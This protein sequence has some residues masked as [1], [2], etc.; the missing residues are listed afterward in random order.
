MKSHEKGVGIFYSVLGYGSSGSG[1][2]IPGFSPLMFE[3]EVVDKPAEE[4]E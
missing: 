2:A 4:E 1:N 3:I